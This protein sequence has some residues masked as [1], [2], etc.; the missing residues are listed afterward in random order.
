MLV[1][2]RVFE[3]RRLPSTRSAY[4]LETLPKLTGELINDV[5]IVDVF[6]RVTPKILGAATAFDEYTLRVRATLD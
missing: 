4:P 5:F 1:V 6:A 3:T 2:V